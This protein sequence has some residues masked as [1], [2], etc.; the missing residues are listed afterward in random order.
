MKSSFQ[1]IVFAFVLKDVLGSEGLCD[2]D[3]T[4]GSG[5][6]VIKTFYQ[7]AFQIYCK[8]HDGFQSLE[9][10]VEG[11]K[12]ADK[13]L[14]FTAEQFNSTSGSLWQ[15]LN[16][17]IDYDYHFSTLAWHWLI[18]VYLDQKNITKKGYFDWGRIGEYLKSVKVTVYG[19]SEW[20][21]TAPG[22]N[23]TFPKPAGNSSEGNSTGTPEHHLT[24]ST[25]WIL[26]SVLGVIIIMATLGIA[27]FVYRI[28]HPKTCV[29]PR[30]GVEAED[31]LNYEVRY[32]N[33]G[34]TSVTRP[35]SA[36]DSEN[37]LYGAL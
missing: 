31:D 35:G 16:V 33:G 6:K 19:Q 18:T 10:K 2:A 1:L 26:V 11:T 14:N 28:K 25:L 29:L 22:G 36:H 27:I 20:R 7:D 24:E 13:T 37:S 34:N 3:V 9:L 32:A 8:L 15:S 5:R 4:V 17:I 30:V 23:C 21:F 12:R